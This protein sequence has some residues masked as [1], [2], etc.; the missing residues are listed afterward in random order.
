MPNAISSSHAL[1]PSRRICNLGAAA[2]G[3]V[4]QVYPKF[5]VRQKDIGT[6]LHLDAQGCMQDIYYLIFASA[7]FLVPSRINLGRGKVMEAV[8]PGPPWLRV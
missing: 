6:S 5:L 3:H 7:R 2:L 8:P 4:P 1:N